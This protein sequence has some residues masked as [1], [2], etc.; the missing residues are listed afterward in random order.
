MPAPPAAGDLP[1]L[2]TCSKAAR[3]YDDPNRQHTEFGVDV[4]LDV[5][6]VVDI[7][8]NVL[9]FSFGSKASDI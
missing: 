8:A 1:L 3:A 5:V 7:V 9:D 6:V 4:V 2:A